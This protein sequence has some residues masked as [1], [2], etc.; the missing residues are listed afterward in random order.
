MGLVFEDIEMIPLDLK[1]ILRG[2]VPDN[3]LGLR[4]VASFQHL[5]SPEDMVLVNV[6]IS[7]RVVQLAWLEIATMR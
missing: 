5:Q 7:Q 4:E 3:E 1:Q 2:S 6:R